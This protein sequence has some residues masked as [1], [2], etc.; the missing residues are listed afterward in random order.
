V[1]TQGVKLAGTGVGT[2]WCGCSRKGGE[3]GGKAFGI[4]WTTRDKNEII[5]EGKRSEVAL[6]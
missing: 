4:I 3:V 2:S 1:E 6:R 5:T